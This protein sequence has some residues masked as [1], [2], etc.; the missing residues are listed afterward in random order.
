MEDQIDD[1]TK[2]PKEIFE[3][4]KKIKG[5]NTIVL[6][7]KSTMRG[8]LVGLAGGYMVASYFGLPKIIGMITG[9]MVGAVSGDQISE[10]IDRMK[11]CN[12]LKSENKKTEDETIST[13]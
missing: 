2:Y 4:I 8:A 9:I 10:F 5:E 13:E 12:L 7:S 3:N 1:I 6:K 11:K